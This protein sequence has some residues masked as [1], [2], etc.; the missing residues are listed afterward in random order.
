MQVKHPVS[1]LD[2]ALHQT[3]NPNMKLALSNFI[4]AVVLAHVSLDEFYLGP[5]VCQL[6]IVVNAHERSNLKMQTSYLRMTA[7][8]L[9][10]INLK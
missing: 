8:V 7:I 1:A 4:R 6:F 2:P 5:Q 10:C 3:F 9:C